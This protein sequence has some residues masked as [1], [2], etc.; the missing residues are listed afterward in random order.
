M[1][2]H[3]SRWALRLM[4]GGGAL[5]LFS[6][7]F[8]IYKDRETVSWLVH[9]GNPQ[10]T[11]VYSRWLDISTSQKTS[12][13]RVVGWLGALE[14]QPVAVAPT[15]AGDYSIDGSEITLFARPFQYP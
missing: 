4:M 8:L 7:A 6:S 10:A 3:T 12:L 14:Y 9:P 5:L 2:K 11:S 1:M 15:K 13:E